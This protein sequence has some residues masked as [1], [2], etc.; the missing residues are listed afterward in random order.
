M[1]KILGVTLGVLTA[2]GGFVDIG[3]IVANSETGARF[4]M[5]LA[6]IGLAPSWFLTKKLME[7]GGPVLTREILLLGDPLPAEKMAALGLISRCVP[8]DQLDAEAAKVVDR[9]VRNAPLS[10]RAMKATINRQLAYRD[11]IEHADT[12]DLVRTAMR[13]TDAKE[14][15]RARMDRREPDFTGGPRQNQTR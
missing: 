12:D 3:D 15:V 9:L 1:K 14:G 6:Q 11:G 7:V 13:S 2:M 10:L 5:S 4:G 8:P